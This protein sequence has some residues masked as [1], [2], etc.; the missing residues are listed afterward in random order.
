MQAHSAYSHTRWIM[1]GSTHRAYG[2][3]NEFTGVSGQRQA[4]SYREGEQ[5]A[6]AF[7]TAICSSRFSCYH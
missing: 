3:S 7:Q 5:P 6:A 4:G 1:I 2:K